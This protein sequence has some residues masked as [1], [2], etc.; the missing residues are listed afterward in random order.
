MIRNNNERNNVKIFIH[1]VTN[2]ENYDNI[3]LA[4]NS[5]QK[6]QKVFVFL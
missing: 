3:V 6:P 1:R 2:H 5:Q 4:T